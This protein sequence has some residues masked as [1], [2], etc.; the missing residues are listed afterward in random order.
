MHAGGS[1]LAVLGTAAVLPLI[2][3][4]VGRPMWH[5]D[6]GR[7][8]PAVQIRALRSLP[9]FRLLP[10]HDLELL[11]ASAQR[12]DAPAGTEIVRQGG[13]GQHFY[14]LVHGAAEVLVDGRRV[15][16]LGPRAGF[17]EVSLMRAVPRSA[18]VV[19]RTDAELYRVPAGDLLAVLRRHPAS[20][21]CAEDVA[22]A[23]LAAD[24]SR[25]EGSTRVAL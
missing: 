11:A 9:H 18:T 14:V 1:G 3:L 4:A 22:A 17:G 12:V 16:T 7:T 2:A 8:R 20:R 15:R 19:A 21:E 6:D 13:V 10:S 23:H 24:R 5:L 25:V